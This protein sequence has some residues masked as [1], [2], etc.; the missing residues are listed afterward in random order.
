MF[1]SD[2]FAV[3][4]EEKN[5][6]KLEMGSCENS[7]VMD[8]PF[9]PS[10]AEQHSCSEFSIH[11]VPEQ[12]SCPEPAHPSLDPSVDATGG[13]DRCM[14]VSGH[15]ITGCTSPGEATVDR[16]GVVSKSDNVDVLALDNLSENQC[17]DG[18]GCLNE[19]QDDIDVFNEETGC[20]NETGNNNGLQSE[21]NVADLLV[22]SEPPSEVVPV[23]GLPRSC[24][25]QVADEEI[26]S[27]SCLCAEEEMPPSEVVHATGSPQSYVQQDA[28]E[29]RSA[30][31]LSAE[32][33]MHSSEVVHVTGSPISCIQQDVEE[34]RS[35]SC[36]SAEEEIQVSEE[37]DDVLPE[38]NTDLVKQVCP[39]QVSELPLDLVPMNGLI[40]NNVEQNEQ[41]SSSIGCPDDNSTRKNVISADGVEANICTKMSVLKNG[42]MLSDV[43]A[44]E[45]VSHNDWRNDQKDDN[46]ID[47]LSSDKIT[48][49]FGLKGNLDACTQIL[50]SL[51]CQKTLKDVP[52]EQN[53]KVN[54]NSIDSSSAGSVTVLVEEK[55]DVTT[56]IEVEIGTQTLLLEENTCKVMEGSSG[57]SSDSIVEKSVPSNSCQP[58]IIVSDGLSRMLDLQSQLGIDVSGPNSY[59]SA[60]GCSEQ[61]DNEGKNSAK[62]DCVSET[63]CCDIVSPSSQRSSRRGKSKQKTKT[64]KSAR[65]CRNTTKVSTSHGSVKLVLET[66]R[67]KRSCLSK[68][69]RSSIWGLL[70][71]VT[72]LFENCNGLEV[73]QVQNRGS[74]KRKGQKIGKQK[75]SGGAIGISQVSSAKC[76]ASTNGLRLKVKLGKAVG[77]SCLNITVPE[78]SKT[79]PSNTVVTSDGGTELCP[80]NSGLGSPKLVS[81][82]EDGLGSDK[83]TRQLQFPTKNQQKLKLCPDASALDGQ[84]ANRDLESNVITQKSLEDS[85]D[86]FVVVEEPSGGPGESRCKDPGTSPDSEVINLTPDV[87]VDSGTCEDLHGT[88]LTSPSDSVSPVDLT[89]SKKGKKKNK[90]KGASNCTVEDGLPC[91]VRSNKVNLSKRRGKKQNSSDGFCSSETLTSSASANASSNSS[92]EKE[93]LNMAG[94]TELGISVEAIKMES[95]T[96]AKSHCNIRIGLGLLKSQNSKNSLPAA[97]T[98][99]H[100]V[101]K[102]RSKVSDSGSKKV[103][104][105]QKETQQKP[106]NKKKTKEK[107]SYDQVDCKVESNLEEGIV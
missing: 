12:Q 91:L 29:I 38:A 22:D 3:G 87:H 13:P 74:R 4:C 42:E 105:K 103:N 40:G 85:R 25:Q 101:P 68:P 88:V 69:A 96:E 6:G 54:D 63:K 45:E 23:T 56:N 16:D 21:D 93:P 106:V 49:F 19:N 15:D 100:A 78:V 57:V 10:I 26:R 53:E 35:A 8:E 75:N 18:G 60:V 7:V 50:S 80:K 67:K 2:G 76:G 73:I 36:L 39:L 81:C 64:K 79:L 1:W 24:V 43:H 89:S 5:I 44:S 99:G 41:D 33:E 66:T 107:A 52:V 37:K 70:G 17:E 62:V 97:K 55:S 48:D 84:L 82:I 61:M 102:S 86:D 90:S 31:H 104:H 83:T 98:K 72:Q 46:G 58:L 71:N 65:K 11:S 20:N 77:Q 30:S 47:S 95:S 34:I 9:C 59:S 28:E 32:E 51:D 94:E 27:A 92:S 14:D